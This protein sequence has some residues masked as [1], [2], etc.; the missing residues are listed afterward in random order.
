MKS[1]PLAASAVLFLLFSCSKSDKKRDPEPLKPNAWALTTDHKLLGFRIEEPGKIITNLAITGIPAGQTLVGLDIRPAD[2]QLYASTHTRLYKIN[3]ETAATTL[4]STN[5]YEFKLYSEELGI[6]FNPV[7][8]YL[9]IVGNQDENVVIAPEDGHLVRADGVINPT[10]LTITASAYSNNFKG[11]TSTTLYHITTSGT[12]VK[13]YEPPTGYVNGIG[14]LGI[15]N[16]SVING[17]D[18]SGKDNRAYAALTTRADNVTKLYRINLATGEATDIATF[19][20][21]IS[22]LALEL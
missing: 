22:G 10:V 12:L 20:I 2:G 11:A 3:R 9:R 8:D 14:Q 13:Q 18:I 17:F 1:T 16:L 19:P 4:Y 15:T 7:S 5:T 6:D 21:H